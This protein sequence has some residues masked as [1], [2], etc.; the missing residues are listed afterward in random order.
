M[1]NEPRERL[2]T[3]ELVSWSLTS[4]FSTNM[5]ISETTGTD[6]IVKSAAAKQAEMVRNAIYEKARMTGRRNAWIMK[7]RADQRKP[8]EVIKKLSESTTRLNAGS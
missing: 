8:G 6:D 7:W 3:D 5:A 1:R 4:L 2:G